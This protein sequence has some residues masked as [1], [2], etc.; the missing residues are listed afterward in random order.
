MCKNIA[1][2]TRVL[3][4]KFKLE[5]CQIKKHVDFDPNTFCSETITRPWLQDNLEKYY[6][7]IEIDEEKHT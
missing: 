1:I 7:K 2:V 5:W 6:P 3:M 4:E